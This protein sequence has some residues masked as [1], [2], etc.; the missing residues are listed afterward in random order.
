MPEKGKKAQSGWLDAIIG[1]PAG[2]FYSICVSARVPMMNKRDAANRK[3]VLFRNPRRVPSVN[4]KLRKVNP[5]K[6]SRRFL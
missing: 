4:S 1:L 5:P 2:L 6:T 3:H